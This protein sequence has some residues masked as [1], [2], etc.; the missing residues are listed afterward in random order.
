MDYYQLRHH[1]SRGHRRRYDTAREPHPKPLPVE[2]E[3]A[4]VGWHTPLAPGKELPPQALDV[5][6]REVIWRLVPYWESAAWLTNPAWRI[7]MESV[8][9]C[10]ETQDTDI[11]LCLQRAFI[12]TL[13]GVYYGDSLFYGVDDLYHNAY[14]ALDQCR[15]DN[16]CI[17]IILQEL[18]A[19]EWLY[20]VWYH[21]DQPTP[22]PI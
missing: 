12:P 10:V 18:V 22:S 4:P 2:P 5:L 11:H 15:S 13:D 17:E 7:W 9:R 14:R 6:L 3:L 19:L 21:L 8:I 1:L 16:D 20:E